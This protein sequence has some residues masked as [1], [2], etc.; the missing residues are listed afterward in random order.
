VVLEG[1][2]DI[3]NWS[4]HVDPV[5][6]KQ[7]MER[8]CKFIPALSTA[9]VIK[10]VAGLTPG[11]NTVRLEVDETALKISTVIHNYGHGGQGVTLLRGCAEEVIHLVKTTLQQKGFSAFI[12]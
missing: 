5:V 8:C 6:S 3:G 12:K 2:A 10:E 7:I 4:D 11:R 1:I 9:E